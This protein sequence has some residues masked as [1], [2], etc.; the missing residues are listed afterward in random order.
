MT[1]IVVNAREKVYNYTSEDHCLLHGLTTSVIV[2]L[3]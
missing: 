2:N 1:F 3:H